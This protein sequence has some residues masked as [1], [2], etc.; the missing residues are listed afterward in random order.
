MYRL[1]SW[2]GWLTL[3]LLLTACA[4]LGI[5]KADQATRILADVRCVTVATAAG[6]QI[7]GDPAV[8]GAKTALDVLS[9]ITSIGMSNTPSAVIEACKDTLAYA[10]EDAK[11]ALALV[12]G[13]TASDAPKATAPTKMAGAPPTQPKAPTPVVIL[14]PK[15][16]EK[17]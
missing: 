7:F 1:R 17:K 16:G 4:T 8:N 5:G 9:A 6:M 2:F 13:G 12:T 10:A 11:G 3:P 14:I 15:K